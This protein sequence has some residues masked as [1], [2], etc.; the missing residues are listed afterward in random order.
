MTIGTVQKAV[1]IP[2]QIDSAHSNSP[3]QSKQIIEAPLKIKTDELELNVPRKDPDMKKTLGLGIQVAGTIG[4]LVT[5]FTAKT[6]AGR[7]IGIGMMAAGVLADNHLLGSS[8]KNSETY[9]YLGSLGSLGL[10]ATVGIMTKNPYMG[11]SVAAIGLYDTAQ[12]GDPETTKNMWTM[13]GVTGGM[14]GGLVLALTSKSPLGM[15]AGGGIIMGSMKL[16]SIVKDW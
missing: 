11:A 2:N 15:A 4:G 10:G 5:T 6:T 13:L 3:P 7:A 14:M 9:S 8:S 12:K 1:T 16:P